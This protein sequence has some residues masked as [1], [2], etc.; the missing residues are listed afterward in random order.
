M[1]SLEHS[2]FQI[3]PKLLIEEFNSLFIQ[4]IPTEY[5]L[6]SDSAVKRVYKMDKT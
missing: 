5:L 2:H 3:I 6:V 1:C 4:H